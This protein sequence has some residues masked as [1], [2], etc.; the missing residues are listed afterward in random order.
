MTN[1]SKILGRK[2]IHPFPARMAPTI[3]LDAL[4]TEKQKP[5]SVLDPMSGSGTVLAVARSAGHRGYGF[6][7]D[8]LAVL[9]SRVWTTA[10]DKKKALSTAADVLH[11]AQGAFRSLATRDAYPLNS[12]EEVRQFVRYWFDP[13]VRRQLTALSIAIK[14][15]SQ[16]L[17]QE[18][19]WCSFSRMIIAKCTSVSRAIDLPHS[20]PNRKNLRGQRKPFSV[21]LQCVGHVVANC[22][23]NGQS[24]RGPVTRIRQGDARALSLPDESMDLVVTS[25]PYL[26]AIDYIRTSKFSLIWMGYTLHRLRSIRRDSIGS[27]AAFAHN[28]TKKKDV[29][30]PDFWDS[31]GDI[32]DL[33]PRHKGMIS[34]YAGDMWHSIGESRR[35]LK[36][37]GKLILVVG[38]STI[39]GVFVKNAKLITQLANARGLSLT[40][41]T[42]REIPPNRRYM[43]PPSSPAAG[44]SLQR[45]MRLE[46]VLTFSKIA[47]VN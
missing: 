21:F 43:P 1:V 27:E 45:R 42:T 14:S 3:V 41:H 11:E 39:R 7:L 40:E 28:V 17:T 2:T 30:V 33:S 46:H 15:L 36:T 38:D 44:G 8:P 23:E 9:T 10:I 5:L 22:I 37:T 4:K 29:K 16:G 24:G 26:N 20:R 35:V 32:S 13:Y 18:I 6:D 19:L 34:R 25:P 47:R 12:D 31:L